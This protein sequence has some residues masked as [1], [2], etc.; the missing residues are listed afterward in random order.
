MSSYMDIE[1]SCSITSKLTDINRNK[2]SDNLS[3]NLSYN[4][5]C[6]EENRTEKQQ[7]EIIDSEIIKNKKTTSGDSDNLNKSQGNNSEINSCN[8]SEK[9]SALD[10]NLVLLYSCLDFVPKSVE[11]LIRMTNLSSEDV[12]SGLVLL[13]LHGKAR[14][15]SHNNYS[16]R[17]T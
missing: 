3:D 12:I 13:T 2:S 9:K 7:K 5:I 16:I 11:E 10:S 17:I 15:T 1:S 8:S 6:I 4:S 14:Q